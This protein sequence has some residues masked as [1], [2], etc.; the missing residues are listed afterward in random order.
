MERVR[1][2]RSYE[3]IAE[4]EG[5]SR[6]RIRQIVVEALKKR[7]V[8]AHRDHA[9]LQLLRLAPALRL[10]AQGVAEGDRR[11]IV[12]LIRVLDRLDKYQAAGV[13]EQVYDENTRQK[14][15]DKLNAMARRMRDARREVSDDSADETGDA[16][17]ASEAGQG[18]DARQEAA[19]SEKPDSVLPWGL[20]P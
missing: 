8:D 17:G 11:A 2:G 5:L 14:L 18:E 12:A 3:E 6:E 15:L 9:R 10:A 19:N 7:E 16:T 4:A 13:A 20:R 1:E